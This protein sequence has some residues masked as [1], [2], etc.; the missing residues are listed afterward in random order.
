M[1]KQLAAA[2]EEIDIPP[3]GDAIAEV[4]ALIDRLA[5]KLS[6]A[7]G[8]FDADGAWAID[9]STSAMA[10]LRHHAG[11][12]A[13]TANATVRTARTLRSLPVT[14]TAWRDGSLSGSQVQVIVAN[15]DDRTLS[16]LVAQE[17]SLVPA[18]APLS[19]TATGRAMRFWRA[20]AEALADDGAEGRLPERDVRLS[21]TFRGRWV[22]DG[23]LDPEGG[24]LLATA[25]RLA[26][27]E[28]PEGT[29]VRTP[30][31]RR[32]DALVDLA[33]FFL[34]HRHDV[35]AGRNRPHL[36]VVVNYDELLAG[37]GG[38]TV[39]GG[40]LDGASIRRLL[41]DASVHRVV[42]DGRST[43]LDYG[44]ATRTA[45]AN[46]WAALVLRDRHCRHDGCDRPPHW[47]EAHHVTPVLEG[48]PT[49]LDNLVLK[50]S[51]HHHLGHLPGWHEKLLP[52]GTLVTTDPKGRTRTTR[53]PGCLPIIKFD[54]SEPVASRDS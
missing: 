40:F 9:G 30:A 44:T 4:S 42:T 36:N 17:A 10:W 24:E 21:Q 32:G 2:V 28:D 53:P 15:V 47:C 13:S 41:C 52:D 23:D 31:R 22:L 33:R 34:D 50:C 26:T 20:R 45:P 3:V 11:M 43:I 25:L 19:T 51:R 14:S 27:T 38:E 46:L 7:V 1:F 49:S 39:D 35:P 29:P 18:V 54:V 6:H 12:T 8:R 37:R 16:Q 5:A 48:G